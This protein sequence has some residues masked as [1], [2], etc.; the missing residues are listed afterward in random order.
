M[1]RKNT[2]VKNKI[3]KLVVGVMVTATVLS[4]CDSAQLSLNSDDAD[5]EE[6]VEDASNEASTDDATEYASDNQSIRGDITL[7]DDQVI[8]SEGYID[9]E[10]KCY[11]VAV[12]RKESVDGIF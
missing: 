9:S 11:R 7:E 12:G 2:E 4:G 10:D 5:I 1:E 8:E 3:I 6:S